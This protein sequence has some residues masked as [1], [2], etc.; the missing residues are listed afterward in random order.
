MDTHRHF[1]VAQASLLQ[2]WKRVAALNAHFHAKE[3]LT[4]KSRYYK[5]IL[6]SIVLPILNMTQDSLFV[7]NSFLHIIA[8]LSVML[9]GASS[10]L[11]AFFNY[12]R[13]MTQHE[14]A[15]SGYK[16]IIMIIDSE[17]SKPVDIRQPVEFIV[18]SVQLKINFLAASSPPLK[19]LPIVNN[20]LVHARTVRLHNEF[21]ST[22]EEIE[23]VEEVVL[24]DIATPRP[25][26]FRRYTPQKE[27]Q[28]PRMAPTQH[29]SAPLPK[30]RPSLIQQAA[31]FLSGQ[32]TS[33]G[34]G[35]EGLRDIELSYMSDVEEPDMR[36][37]NNSP[38]LGMRQVESPAENAAAKSASA[39]TE[40]EPN[41]VVQKIIPHAPTLKAAI[42]IGV[43]DI[44]KK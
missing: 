12:S 7:E 25:G 42:G 35:G 10:A 37:I 5:L 33:E 26:L 19:D 15:V 32:P 34:E 36:E 1:T 27:A 8:Y 40:S 21:N 38:V 43:K 28:R 3:A 39:S 9:S 20:A 17:F 16:E 23:M 29:R 18:Q 31:H 6:P 30:K 44:K 4:C 2:R 22:E 24:R 11:S 14:N 41:A 13:L